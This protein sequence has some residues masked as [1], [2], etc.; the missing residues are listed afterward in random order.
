MGEA[1]EPE[2]NDEDH[3][4]MRRVTKEAERL[5]EVL[6]FFSLRMRTLD[7][8]VNSEGPNPPKS[9]KLDRKSQ[10]PPPLGRQLEFTTDDN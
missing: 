7:A 9:T 1:H 2:P 5:R 10:P 3:A 4:A 6:E 8:E